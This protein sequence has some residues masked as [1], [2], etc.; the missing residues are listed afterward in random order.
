M[1]PRIL[2]GVAAATVLALVAAGFSVVKGRP[3]ARAVK[4]DT[5]L[6]PG[7]IDKTGSVA[8]VDIVHE[9]GQVTIKREGAGWVVAEMDNYPAITERVRKTVVGLAELKLL[10]AKTKRPD[11]FPRLQVEDVA[12]EKAQ[13]RVLRLKDASGGVIA[14]A[15]VGKFKLN[16]GGAGRQGVYIR[17]AGDNQS[18]LA[19][20][21]VEVNIDPH[22]WAVREITDVAPSRIER[23]ATSAHDGTS[24][25]VKKSAP[26]DAHFT[27]ENPPPADKLKA[28]SV[29]TADGMASGL[30]KA[31]FTTIA[32]RTDKEKDF[33]DA[34]RF[35]AELKT[36][37]GL[38]VTVDIFEKAAETWGTF[39]ASAAPDAADRAKI[40]KE[41][42]V[43][44]SKL[45][46]WIYRLPAHKVKA[47]KTG[48]A[49]ISKEEKKDDK[50]KAS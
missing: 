6:F 38:I 46:A 47:L 23:I 16:L 42:A 41:A 40:E 27:I 22:E 33:A 21:T 19:E 14:E 28:D 20:G 43:L 24:L 13:S 9:K 3:D 11:R 12:T 35:K 10:E 29:A 32:R 39:K 15:V 26:A 44:N 50:K 5:P 17:K 31:D 4:A 1:T 45:G 8:E 25:V 37:D 30:E 36:F 7:L 2:T 18:W 48:V 49:D 34:E